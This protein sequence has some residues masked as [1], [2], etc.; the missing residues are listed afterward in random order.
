M[1]DTD[2]IAPPSSA[3]EWIRLAETPGVGPVGAARLLHE[4]ASPARIFGAGADALAAAGVSR[5]AAR[6][7]CQPLPDPAARRL[8]AALAWLE[9]PGH[10]LL[11]LAGPGYPALLAAIHAPPT[12]LYAAG[13]PEL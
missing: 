7:L 10:H 6:A 8:D 1:Q 12:L 3:S 5:A 13:F 9:R 4:F 11:T 2:P